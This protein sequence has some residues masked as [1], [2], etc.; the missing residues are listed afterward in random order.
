MTNW[1]APATTPNGAPSLTKSDAGKAHDLTSLRE[2]SGSQ[3]AA[4]AL[5]NKNARILWAVM[6]KI[7]T[8]CF[9]RCANDFRSMAEPPHGFVVRPNVEL[10]VNFAD[11]EQVIQLRFEP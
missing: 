4:V 8:T 7:G 3:V 9:A 2:C 6:T 11:V 1:V 5:T 10:G